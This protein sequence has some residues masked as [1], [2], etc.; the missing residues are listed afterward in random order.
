MRSNA[1][2][3]FKL[4]YLNVQAS[5]L[6]GR[7]HPVLSWVMTTRDVAISRPHIKML[8][9]DYMCYANLAHDRGLDPQCRVCQVLHHHPAPTENL[10][11]LLTRCRATADTRDR[12]M[13]ELINTVAKYFPSN[14]ILFGPNH[15][16]LTQFILDCSSLNLPTNT[17]VPPI[18]KGFIPITKECSNL[19]YAIHQDRTRQMKALGLLHRK[20]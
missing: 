15:S 10:M 4:E 2:G 19:I 12:I 1:L 8:A 5:G 3:N 7:P 17:R 6:S 9:G 14:R 13:P 18:H 16:I 11:H 20:Y